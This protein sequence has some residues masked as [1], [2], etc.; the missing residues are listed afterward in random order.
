MSAFSQMVDDFLAAYVGE[1]PL[2]ATNLGIDGH[3]DRL[4]DLS[5]D[6]IARRETLLDDWRARFEAAMDLDEHERIDRDMICSSIAKTTLLMRWGQWRRNPASYIGQGLEGVFALFLHRLRPDAELARD[7]AA[8]LRAV[9]GVLHEGKANIDPDIAAPVFIQRAIDSCKAAIGYCRSMV[10]AEVPGDKALAEAGEIAAAAYE[11]FAAFLSDLDPR[12]D[13]AIGAQ[14]YSEMLRAS[15]LLP[16]GVEEL[17]ERGRAEYD[18]LAA[19]MTRRARDLEGTDDWVKALEKINASHPGDP[20]QMRATYAG[21]TERARAFLVEKGLATLPEGER[22]MVEP[23]PPFTRPVMAVASYQNAPA[24]KPSLTG[25]FFVPYPPDGEPD[26]RVAKR[27]EANSYAMIP[28]ISVHEAYP[29]H[30]WHLT[31][32]NTNARTARKVFGSSYF[33][34]GWALYSEM[35][36]LDEGFYDDPRH[37]FGVF[38]ARIFRAARVVVDTSLHI[39]DMSVEEAVDFMMTK[40]GLPEPTARAEVGRY[41][42]WPTQASS[43]LTGALEIERMRERWFAEGRGDLRAFHDRITSSGSLP[44]ALAERA[45][46][47]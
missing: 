16:Y 3:D 24:F 27:L 23:S 47:G 20:E 26:D 2:T 43:Y 34:E 15:E 41:C 33:S 19:E 36:M 39:G 9:P 6:G 38:S 4:A 29:G 28:T 11:D 37:E 42:T 25:H 12:G 40:T 22:C 44:L 17:R 45:V 30:H 35:M 5:A 32:M 14:M 21:W 1:F 10:P 7:A 8:R 18:T 31:M 13:Y 46:F